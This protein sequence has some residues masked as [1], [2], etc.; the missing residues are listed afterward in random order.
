[1]GIIGLME[2][3]IQSLGAAGAQVHTGVN[4]ECLAGAF[5]LRCVCPLGKVASY[6]PL[7]VESSCNSQSEHC[8]QRSWHLLDR[9]W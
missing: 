4:A 6:I 2:I 7:E 9:V 1:M 8:M 5:P 3:G